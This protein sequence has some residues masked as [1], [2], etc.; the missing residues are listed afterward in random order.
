MKNETKWDCMVPCFVC[1]LIGMILGSVILNF[2][3]GQSILH[4]TQDYSLKILGAYEGET[5]RYELFTFLLVQRG[6]VYIG[7]L[8]GIYIFPKKQIMRVFWFC[9][10]FLFGIIISSQVICSGIMALY[11]IIAMAFPHIFIYVFGMYS[12]IKK[13]VSGTYGS[14]VIILFLSYLAGVF[15]ESYFSSWFFDVLY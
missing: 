14:M 13:F 7:L 11:E 3:M 12:G 4:N 6:I 10:S 5:N 1:V 9:F 8:I 15:S 2:M